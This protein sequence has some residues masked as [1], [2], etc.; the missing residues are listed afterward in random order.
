[1]SSHPPAIVAL[2]YGAASLTTLSFI[3]QALKTIRTG[4]TRG[5][6][7]RMYA[8]FTAGIALW[9]I[10]GLLTRDGPLVVANAITIVA[11]GLILERK[12]RAYRAGTR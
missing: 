6:S 7:L 10:Y 9:G 8:L 12:W 11:A 4:D 1:M 5:I 3:P 2:G